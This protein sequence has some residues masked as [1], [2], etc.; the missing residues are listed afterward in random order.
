MFASSGAHYHFAFSV[1]PFISLDPVSSQ[2]AAFMW[3]NLGKSGFEALQTSQSTYPIPIPTIHG[4]GISTYIWL[5]FV[6]KCK[7][8]IT[9]MH[10]MRYKECGICT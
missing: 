1:W 4:T 10:G 8:N 6:G 7:V 2:P 3:L 9:Y 5:I